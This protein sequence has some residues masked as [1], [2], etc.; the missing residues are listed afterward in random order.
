MLHFEVELA[1][2][3]I[4]SEIDRLVSNEVWMNFYK[5][6]APFL[7]EIFNLKDGFKISEKRVSDFFANPTDQKHTQFVLRDIMI[8]LRDVYIAQNI[9]SYFNLIKGQKISLYT[10][11]GLNH[12]K[13]VT[14]ILEKNGFSPIILS[15]DEVF[16]HLEKH[17]NLHREEF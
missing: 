1:V 17:I 11:L 3:K 6:L 10:M 5:E 4:E 15:Q 7:V 12:V 9:A 2:H 13:G 14:K 8:D 16:S